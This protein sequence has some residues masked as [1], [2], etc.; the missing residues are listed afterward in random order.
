MNLMQ[1]RA[2]LSALSAAIFAPARAFA[3]CQAIPPRP[4]VVEVNPLCYH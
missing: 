1:G 2:Q 3:P 4:S